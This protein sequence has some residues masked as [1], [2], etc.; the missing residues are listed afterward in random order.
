MRKL[1]RDAQQ[2]G[3]QRRD[4]AGRAGRS[5]GVEGHG[6]KPWREVI[7]PHQD[8][9][10]REHP[11]RGVR[12]RPVLRVARRGV[13]REY[14]DPVEFFR[15]TY[16]TEGLRD[17]LLRRRGG[18][19]GTGTPRRCG[20]C[21][22]TSAAARRTRCWRCSTCCPGP[23]WPS[24]RTRCGRCS[25]GTTSTLGR[26][27][28]RVVLVGNHIAAGQGLGQG[29]T[30]RTCGRCGASWPGSSAL[31][32]GGE[33]EARARVRDRRG[34]PT[35]PGPTRRAALGDADRRLRAV[36]DPD[37]RVGRLRAAALRAR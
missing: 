29:R 11:R 13:S 35:R 34:T 16:L 37:R 4:A 30:G 23:S 20:T 7:T 12:R 2:A 25:P 27:A 9:S 22:R 6:L 28:R 10:G 17:L 33:A 8:V 18:S 5:T 26:S 31:P 21:R 15:R 1:R 32:A 36:P 24:T 19:A 3:V 14:V